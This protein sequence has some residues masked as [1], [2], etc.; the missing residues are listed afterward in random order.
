MRTVLL[1][2]LVVAMALLSPAVASAGP[3]APPA[4]EPQ[5]ASR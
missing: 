4:G 5:G 2:P 3:G 1:R